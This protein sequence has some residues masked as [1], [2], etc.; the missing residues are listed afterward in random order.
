MLL[1][2]VSTSASWPCGAFSTF[3][4]RL[5]RLIFFRHPFPYHRVPPALRILIHGTYRAVV[6]CQ[7]I[8]EIGIVKS[9]EHGYAIL[10]GR[11][12]RPQQIS[13]LLS[14]DFAEDVFRHF[15]RD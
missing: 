12:V 11:A 9:T 15:P 5:L 4:P 8:A 14:L 6:R 1:V 10:G 13:N 2:S 7:I 3:S